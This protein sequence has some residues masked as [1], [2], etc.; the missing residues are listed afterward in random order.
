MRR[1]FFIPAILICLNVLSLHAQEPK[2]LAGHY[3]FAWAGDRARHCFR[4]GVNREFDCWAAGRDRP[5]R[6]PPGRKPVGPSHGFH[7]GRA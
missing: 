4:V 6:V 7:Q 1:F 5:N 2:P 3:L